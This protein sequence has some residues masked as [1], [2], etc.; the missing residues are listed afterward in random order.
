MA[1]AEQERNSLPGP[2]T[3]TAREG[4][5]NLSQS[6]VPFSRRISW[7]VNYLAISEALLPVPWPP[8]QDFL[9]WRI[10]GVGFSTRW[11][12]SVCLFKL[13]S[14]GS[15]KKGRLPPWAG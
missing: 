9:K 8:N 12:I 6:I 5:N 1:R 2:S 15:C 14:S 11:V 10:G 13:N 3:S 7:R 4:R